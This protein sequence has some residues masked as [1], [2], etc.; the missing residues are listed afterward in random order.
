MRMTSDELEISDE[1]GRTKHN[2]GRVTNQTNDD[3][4]H[5]SPL[6][7]HASHEP[8]GCIIKFH[9]MCSR[10]SEVMNNRVSMPA[11]GIEVDLE[12]R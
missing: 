4:R 12:H 6:P 10:A 5:L 2:G 9:Q 3:G 1:D 7:L 11:H 8:R